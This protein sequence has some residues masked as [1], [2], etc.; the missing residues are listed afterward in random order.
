MNRCRSVT[1]DPAK[2]YFG[3]DAS[4]SRGILGHDGDAGLKHVG[5]LEVVETGQGDG[6]MQ[7]EGAGR[8]PADRAASDN[9][10]I[11]IVGSM[12]VLHSFGR[13]RDLLVNGVIDCEAMITLTYTLDRYRRHRHV[14]QRRRPEGASHTELNRLELWRRSSDRRQPR[15]QKRRD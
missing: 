1:V 11:T 6:A 4:H 8:E 7:P 12:A 15:G 10:E 9:D 3:C 2:Q 13:A 5:E 14:P